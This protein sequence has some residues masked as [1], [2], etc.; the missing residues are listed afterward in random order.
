MEG[1][2]LRCA[3]Y[4]VH[5]HTTCSLQEATWFPMGHAGGFSGTGAVPPEREFTYCTQLCDITFKLHST[6]EAGRAQAVASGWGATSSPF[7]CTHAAWYFLGSR[8]QGLS[9][10]G[11]LAAGVASPPSPRAGPGLRLRG[12]VFRGFWRPVGNSLGHPMQATEERSGTQAHPSVTCSARPITRGVGW[13]W[14]K[15][16]SS[17]PNI[18]C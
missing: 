18:W 14:E 4:P 10:A 2:P 8:L 15:S 5:L 3:W 7:Y 9:A 16:T 12:L 6:G 13:W 1:T 11:G 17:F